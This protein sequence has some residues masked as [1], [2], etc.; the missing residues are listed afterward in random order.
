MAVRDREIAAVETNG[1]EQLALQRLKK[2]VA[3]QTRQ[4]DAQ[5]T[6]AMLMGFVRATKGDT[7]KA[8]GHWER[9]VGRRAEFMPQMEDEAYVNGST[10]KDNFVQQIRK[11]RKAESIRQSATPWKKDR[12]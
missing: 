5:S 9:W 3:R 11:E 1:D 12:S 2:L 10:Y 4:G 7:F 6:D 8:L